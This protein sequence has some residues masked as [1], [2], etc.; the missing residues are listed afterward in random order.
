MLAS[1]FAQLRHVTRRLLHAPL[2]TAVAVVTLAV[3]IGANTA[4]FSLVYGVLLKPLPFE[5][6]ETLVGVW[7]E[8]PGLNLDLLNQS[9]AT[10]LTYREDGR[11]FEDI[12]MWDDTYVAITG[13]QEPERVEA[14]RV[15]DGL[16]PLLRVEPLIGRRFT[17]ED[18]SPAGASTAM[19]TYAY[20]QRKFGGDP[21]VLGQ[22]LVVEGTTREIVGVLPQSFKFLRSNAALVLPF[23][24]DRSEVFVGNFS[25]QGIA[26]LKPGVTIEQA[27]ADVARMIPLLMEKFPLPPGFS[28]EMLNEA[29]LGPKVRPLADDVIG[30]VG[31]V[32]WV[33]LGTVGIVLLIACANV[34]NLFLIRA[35]GRQ[36][37]LAIRTAMGAG[38][39]Q[40]AG[41]T[42]SE[43]I[44]L[45]LV[46]GAVG[47]GLAYLGIQL[48]LTLRPE[49]LPR[50]DEIALDPV[51]MLFTLGISLTAGVL[52]GLI[53]VWRISRTNLGNALKEGSRG[54]SEGKERHRV[55]TALVTAEIALALVLLV[56]AGL[57]FRTFQA[58]RDV[59]PG[60]VRPAEVLTARISIPEAVVEDPVEAVR[61]H[62]QIKERLGQLPGVTA[63]GLSSSITMDGSDSRD[64]VF[65]EEFPGPAGQIPPIR[66]FKWVA[67]EFF[68]TMGNPLLMG[69]H[70][71]WTDSYNMLPVAI[72]NDAFVR[73]YW[74]DPAD[75]LG[76]RIRQT[77]ENQ[78][79]E[80]VGIVGN[81]R[82]D[83]VAQPAPPIVYWPLLQADFWD[84]GVRAQR[85]LGYA[86]RSQRL[87]S[88]TFLREIQDAV[89]SVNPNLPLSGVQTLESLRADSM[90]QTSF[91]LVL[92]AVAASV[93]LLLSIVGIYGVI[94]YAATQRT[95][96][97]G[98]RMALG[99]KHGDVR[100]LFVRHGLM[101]T[102]V[103]VGVGL[104]AAMGL[105]RLMS[106]LLYGISPLDPV[107]Y[108]AV[109]VGLALTAMLASYLPARRAARV[110]PV[111]ALRSGA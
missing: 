91:A 71:T 34:A 41:E 2:F 110:D 13:K 55:R 70:M 105:T 24:L 87:S 62:E 72:V 36:Q 102:V 68:E 21:N 28:P 60:F 88:P 96:E 14:L 10:Y 15:T 25:Y 81:E 76:K 16:L 79:R 95:R 108:G 35:E 52:F 59:D 101:L 6:P 40:V 20:W 33:L 19:L 3:G 80:I 66:K 103:G 45:G 9:P 64:P 38:R 86:V 50:L 107:T 104:A 85:W 37:E 90:A 89:W 46:G 100:D 111:I 54:S 11:T 7:H 75:A 49:G 23:R 93:A 58:M 83:G 29:R 56:A 74:E 109:A 27:N 97:I 26:R 63:V 51:V 22:P 32:L 39:R 57:M 61:T 43:S 92:L 84:E 67:P 77:P 18:D 42:L 53:P 78:W 94:A 4:I 1:L 73:E 47:L 31:R 65:V 12:G 17:P 30:D 5:Q 69:R 106:A 82:D 99:A 44:T 48:L 98:I 8:A